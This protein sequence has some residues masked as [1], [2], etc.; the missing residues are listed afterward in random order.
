MMQKAAYAYLQTNLTT[1]SPGETI[2][3][4]YD[5]AVAFLN[6]A[7]EQIDLKD[8]AQKGILIGKAIDIINELSASLNRDKGGDIADNLHQ[9]YFLCNTRLAMANLK[10]DKKTIDGVIQVLNG[11]RDAF[12]Q[13]QNT[14]EAQAA[15]EELNSRQV[16]EA[17]SHARNMH[18]S[19]LPPPGQERNI[20]LRGRNLYNK[21][22]LN[23]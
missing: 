16:S 14:P 2:L 18:N 4:L 7:K 13:I 17:S 21:M 3:T 12:A 20:S 10:M 19:P 1:C 6:R 9:L 8:Y 23:G 22:A 15:T 11:L 5:G